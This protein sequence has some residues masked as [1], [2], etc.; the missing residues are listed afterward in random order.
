MKTGCFPTVKKTFRWGVIESNG[1]MGIDLD[2]ESSGV[3]ILTIGIKF[4]SHI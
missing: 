1:D 4:F 3:H 2:I